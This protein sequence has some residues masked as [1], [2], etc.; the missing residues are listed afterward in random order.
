[1]MEDTA[2][3]NNIINN[4]LSSSSELQIFS[5]IHSTFTQVR[6]TLSPLKPQQLVHVCV[7]VCVSMWKFM[8]ASTCGGPEA[9]KTDKTKKKRGKELK[10]IKQIYKKNV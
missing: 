9:T 10:K 7:C 3:I 2:Y 4:I 6:P 5:S 1:M 8:C